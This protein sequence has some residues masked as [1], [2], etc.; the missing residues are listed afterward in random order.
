MKQSSIEAM[1]I[2]RFKTA[3][4]GYRRAV[5]ILLRGMRYTP[6]S[7]LTSLPARKKGPGFYKTQSLYHG[8]AL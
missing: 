8:T 7:S 2:N 1:L 3:L 6:M 5:L 4:P